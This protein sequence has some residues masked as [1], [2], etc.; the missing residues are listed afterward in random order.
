[1]VCVCMRA[2]VHILIVY[3]YTYF[4]TYIVGCSVCGNY[5]SELVTCDIN[6]GCR[7]ILIGHQ[8]ITWKC[9][10]RCP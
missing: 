4:N 3:S 1:M 9:W 5:S 8:M 2:C 6:F 7:K 10:R